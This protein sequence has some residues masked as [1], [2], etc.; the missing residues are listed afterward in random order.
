MWVGCVAVVVAWAVGRRTVH[1]QGRTG[2]SDRA[3][4]RESA[5]SLR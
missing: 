1:K 3:I 4:D 2:K 5:P